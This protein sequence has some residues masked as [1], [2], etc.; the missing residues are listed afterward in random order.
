MITFKQ[1]NP[2]EYQPVPLFRSS[3]EYPL[4]KK[5]SNLASP[6]LLYYVAMWSSTLITYIACG[7]HPSVCNHCYVIHIG[8]PCCQ[9][10]LYLYSTS[11][12]EKQNALCQSLLDI[13]YY[14]IKLELRL[15]LLF[16]HEVYFL[17]AQR[18]RNLGHQ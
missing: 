3:N 5:K 9:Y 11:Q 7:L 2:L 15:A 18:C 4:N 14:C 1:R 13:I 6:R 17:L 12:T 10:E 8:T 16:V